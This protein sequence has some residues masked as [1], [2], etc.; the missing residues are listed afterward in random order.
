MLRYGIVNQWLMNKE[1]WMV[2]ISFAKMLR[3]IHR[4][5]IRGQKRNSTKP[6]NNHGAV[7]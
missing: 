1:E 7:A 4:K 6:A 5:I 2:N 3:D